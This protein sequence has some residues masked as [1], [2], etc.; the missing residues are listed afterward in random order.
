M[1][2]FVSPSIVKISLNTGIYQFSF[3]YIIF[4]V[5]HLS[6]PTKRSS[7]TTLRSR[8]GIWSV[9]MAGDPP[10]PPG[11]RPSSPRILPLCAKLPGS[12]TTSYPLDL[13]SDSLFIKAMPCFIFAHEISPRG[14]I[15]HVSI[16]LSTNLSFY[17]V[18]FMYIAL[19]LFNV[20]FFIFSLV[21][22][23]SSFVHEFLLTGYR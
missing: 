16:F 18:S 15:S 1:G 9:R 11:S 19:P 12:S 17:T 6:V 5:S 7:P 14:D 21:I 4:I 23:A 8:S 20:S 13:I 22:S 3:L 10:P 2:K